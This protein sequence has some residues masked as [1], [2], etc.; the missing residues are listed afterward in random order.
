MFRSKAAVALARIVTAL[1]IT[2]AAQ[3]VMAQRAIEGATPHPM[4]PLPAEG[5]ITR[6]DFTDFAEIEFPAAPHPGGR[7]PEFEE[8]VQ[9]EGAWR[10][11]EYT[12]D[13][14][15][16][17]LL[18]LY[19]GYVQH[20]E[21]SGF[22][23]IF[24]GIG[25]ELSIRDG[26]TFISYQSG[27]LSR[28][29]S[30]AP[31]SNAYFLVRSPDEQTVIAVS[32]F[33]R[34]NARRMMVNAVEIE[35]MAPLDLFS[36]TPEPEQEPEPEVVMVPQKVEELETGLVQD[37]R[38]I[39]NAILFEFDR[40]EILPE[41]AQALETVTDLLRARPELKLLVVGHTD[42]V[43]SFD[44]NLRLSVE[45]AQAVVGWLGSRGG[46]DASRLRAAGAG[47]MSPITTNR[48]ESGRAQNRRVELVEIIE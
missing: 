24:S 7:D 27:F 31:E 12:V 1:C 29:P 14:L 4:V 45:R 43:G 26:F 48:T 5:Y 42:V 21:S 34:Q 23:V 25:E 22:E 2:V 41:S 3:P 46:I 47:P 6:Y 44:Y 33:S 40:A 9:V 10:Q 37:G 11:M 18:R 15:E 16:L 8:T 30:T 36:P 32:F 17:S 13:G 20:F 19:R 38:V 39:V 28:T 35:E